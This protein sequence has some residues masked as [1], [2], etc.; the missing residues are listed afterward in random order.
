M[1]DSIRIRSIAARS[2]EASL[3]VESKEIKREETRNFDINLFKQRTKK[4]LLVD[5]EQYNI[6]ALKIIL[7]YHCNIDS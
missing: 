5:D 4:I 1:H 6:D 7:R 2:S 3:I